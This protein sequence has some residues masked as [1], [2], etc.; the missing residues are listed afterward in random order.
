MALKRDTCHPKSFDCI[1]AVG[2]QKLVLLALLLAPLPAADLTLKDAARIAL[3]DNPHIAAARSLESAAAARIAQAD[4][5]RLPRVQWQESVQ[6]GNNPVYVFSSLLTQRQF[7]QSNF[8]IGSLVR[9][10]PLQNFQSQLG[11]EQSVYDFGRTASRRKEAQFGQAM[12]EQETARRRLEVLIATSRSYYG[13]QLAAAGLLAAQKSVSSAEATLERSRALLAAGLATEADVLAVEVH[14]AG[15]REEVIRRSE[16]AGLA[17][18]ALNHSLG[19]PLETDDILTTRLDAAIPETAPPAPVSRPELNMAALARDAAEA[20]RDQASAML[21]PEIGLRLVLEADRQNVVTKGGANWIA[22]A[23]LRW[24]LFDG[25]QARQMRNEANHAIAAAAAELRHAESGLQLQILQAGSALRAAEERE[26]VTAATV[27][28][29]TETLRILRNRYGAGLATVTD[30]LRAETALL[31]AETR[32]LAALHDRRI[33]AIE[34]EAAAGALNG[35]SN[36]L[37]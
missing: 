6:G 4:A 14:L 23:S 29:A 25:G 26:K 37:N 30:V 3:A 20:R 24:N 2:M 22:A 18:A 35:D 15:A 34:R 17:R 19:R 8:A 1:S 33:A 27:Q 21:R 13:A 28:Q 12:A 16:Q 11:I 9:P 36:V 31:E 10:D 5:A 32:R 7:S